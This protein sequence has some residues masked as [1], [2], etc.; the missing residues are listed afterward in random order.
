M[1]RTEDQ[2]IFKAPFLNNWC[3]IANT[4]QIISRIKTNIEIFQS[5]IEAFAQILLTSGYVKKEK[6][7][8][9]GWGNEIQH[10]QKE[11]GET[12][13]VNESSQ[14]QK[15][16]DACGSSLFWQ[17]LQSPKDSSLHWHTLNQCSVLLC[18]KKPDAAGKW[19]CEWINPLLSQLCC[20]YNSQN[21]RMKILKSGLLMLDQTQKL[22][23]YCVLF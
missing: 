20:F 16:P 10:I 23:C 9:V 1:Q 19:G 3:Y 21:T 5:R 12:D 18:C 13:L 22:A 11:T 7:L 17:L 2:N 14:S 15:P 4:A 8:K 6:R